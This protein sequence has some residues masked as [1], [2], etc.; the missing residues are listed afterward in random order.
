MR[1]V[2]PSYGL[3]VTWF[4]LEGDGRLDLFVG[5][6][7]VPNFVFKNRGDGTFEEVGALSGLSANIDGREQACMGVDVADIDGDLR[8][9]LVVTNFSSDYNTIYRNDGG[10]FFTDVT[11]ILGLGELDWWTL[12]WG[13][14]FFDA[15]CDRDLDLFVANGHIYPTDAGGATPITYEQ[16]NHL[17]LQSKGR[18]ELVS[19]EAGPGLALVKSSRGVAFG[20]LDLDGWMDLVV[21]DRNEPLSI[22]RAVPQPGVHRLL[23]EILPGPDRRPVDH[24]VVVARAGGATMMR[25]MNRGGSY[26]S[27][28]DPRLH[29]GLGD[30]AV[31]DELSVRWPDGTDSTWKDVPA[32]SLVRVRRGAATLEL[33]ALR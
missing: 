12:G 24:S 31:V 4:D 21:I 13:T 1:D 18:F 7:S 5:N 2:V 3:G 32:D 25:R 22:L 20:D 16:V 33:A 28:N 15:D 11:R 30:A 9:E 17:W 29:F 27:S 6:D 26:A 19:D 14:R 23:V 10:G 8:E